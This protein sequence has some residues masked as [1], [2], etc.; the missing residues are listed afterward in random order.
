MRSP[1]HAR[2][3]MM[4]RIAVLSTVLIALLVSLFLFVMH[5]R[6]ARSDAERQNERSTAA[7][8]QAK[9]VEYLLTGLVI[10]ER[11]FEQARDGQFA[12]SVQD[13]RRAVLREAA[14]LRGLVHDAHQ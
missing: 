5:A 14:E 8:V 2:G 6:A 10:G 12:A 13:P 9:Q 1:M 11:A 4:A 3:G 7:E